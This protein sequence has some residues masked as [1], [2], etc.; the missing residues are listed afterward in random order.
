MQTLERQVDIAHKTM[1]LRSAQ[2]SAAA[3]RHSPSPGPGVAGP[4]V[5]QRHI[6]T[7]YNDSHQVPALVQVAP[8]LAKRRARLEV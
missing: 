4:E 1:A 7:A 8:K 3:S 2:G 6:D 5:G